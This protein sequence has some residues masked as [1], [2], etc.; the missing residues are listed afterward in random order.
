MVRENFHEKLF[1]GAEGTDGAFR[2]TFRL[3]SGCEK[4]L[5]IFSTFFEKGV[6]NGKRMWYNLIRREELNTKP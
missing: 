1:G 3:F 4:N 5:K 2:C 6:D